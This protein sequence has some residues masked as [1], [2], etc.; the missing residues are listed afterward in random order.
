MVGA[1]RDLFGLL[2]LWYVR[3]VSRAGGT[4]R[5]GVAPP[6]GGAPLCMVLGGCS[7]LSLAPDGGGPVIDE[8]AALQAL[9]LRI[10]H[11]VSLPDSH[12]AVVV[13]RRG[14]PLRGGELRV[15][16]SEVHVEDASGT[17]IGRDALI[18]LVS[19]E[20][21]ARRALRGADYKRAFERALRGEARARLLAAG[22]VAN[23]LRFVRARGQLVDVFRVEGS[24]WNNAEEANFSVQLEV[25]LAELNARP[26]PATLYDRAHPALGKVLAPPHLLA[27]AVD[28]VALAGRLLDDVE[29]HALPY[30]DRFHSPDD[31]FAE[32]LEEDRRQGA[33]G[34]TGI[35]AEL[36]ARLG[37]KDEARRYFLA[38]ADREHARRMAA[39]FGISLDE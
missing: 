21:R 3:G 26:K 33:S 28:E 16:A 25:L 15:R 22:F 24:R 2:A 29:L 32:L 18:Q 8:P 14:S 37:R 11:P 35:V 6:D 9:E 23:K 13:G 7:V 39:H 20:A 17:R 4:A 31:V 34:R 5:I 1:L 27:G 36:L 10:A 12:V 19:D 30:Y 38:V